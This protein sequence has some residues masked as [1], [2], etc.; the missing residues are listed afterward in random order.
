MLVTTN[1]TSTLYTR[2]I[3]QLLLDTSKRQSENSIRHNYWV[4]VTLGI[5]DICNMY[6]SLRSLASIDTFICGQ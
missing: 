2:E 3:I 4:C 6:K 5:R 1:I